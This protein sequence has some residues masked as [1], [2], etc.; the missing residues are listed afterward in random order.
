MMPWR[1]SRPS[2]RPKYDG[3][4]RPPLHDAVANFGDC[5]FWRERSLA[6]NR[7]VKEDDGEFPTPF[8]KGTRMS[9]ASASLPYLC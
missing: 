5:V 7:D 1:S 2:A 3:S 8:G 6:A 4:I 9:I